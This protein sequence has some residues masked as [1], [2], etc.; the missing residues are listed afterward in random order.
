MVLQ[1][2][3]GDSVFDPAVNVCVPA[4]QATCQGSRTFTQVLI[5][6]VSTVQLVSIYSIPVPRARWILPYS[7]N[8]WK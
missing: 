6:F 4:G 5:V 3:P 2:C 8:M 1:S 7:W